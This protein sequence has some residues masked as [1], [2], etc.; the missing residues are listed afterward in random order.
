MACR[1]DVFDWLPEQR[2]AAEPAAA[3][4]DPRNGFYEAL[5]ADFAKAAAAPTPADQSP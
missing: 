2:E 4:S 5:A 3:L 1:S